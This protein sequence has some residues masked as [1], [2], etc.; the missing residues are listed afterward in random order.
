MTDN[1]KCITFIL[2][3]GELKYMDRKMKEYSQNRH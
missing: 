2:T 1:T 3:D